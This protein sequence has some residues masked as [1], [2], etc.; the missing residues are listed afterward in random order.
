MATD[1]G[2]VKHYMEY[3]VNNK[4]AMGGLVVGGIAV[5]VGALAIYFINKNKRSIHTKRG[6]VQDQ[7]KR[8]KQEHELSY[9]KKKLRK[10]VM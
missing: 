6:W 8:S 7:S 10:K 2:D 5:I 3:Q 4:K 9:Q 1:M